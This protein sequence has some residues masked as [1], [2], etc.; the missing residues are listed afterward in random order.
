M[1]CSRWFV[2]SSRHG[3]VWTG[4]ALHPFLLDLLKTKNTGVI[5]NTPNALLPGRSGATAPGG[6]NPSEKQTPRQALPQPAP[7]VAAAPGR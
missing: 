7:V 1:F 3:P 4:P 5:E 2:V 6:P